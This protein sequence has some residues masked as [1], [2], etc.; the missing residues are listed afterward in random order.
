MASAALNVDLARSVNKKCL[1]AAEEFHGVCEL[2]PNYVQKP[3]CRG[4]YRTVLTTIGFW[5]VIPAHLAPKT[6]RHPTE[7]DKFNINFLHRQ[8][9]R[10]FTIASMTGFPESTIRS[11]IK[12]FE[13]HKSL[14][15]KVGKPRLPRDAQSICAQVSA[16][17]FL[18]VCQ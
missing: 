18:S 4:D 9:M 7:A 12:S 17:P 10:N 16:D 15:P 13:V 6:G 5:V 3:S 1:S 2:D 8:G 14:F 11:I